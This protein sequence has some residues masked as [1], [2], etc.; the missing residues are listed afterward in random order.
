MKHIDKKTMGELAQTLN[1]EQL[2]LRQELSQIG[3]ENPVT[4]DWYAVPM[5][6]DGD[7]E[8]DYSDQADYVEDFESR[9]A[10]LTEIEKRYKDV[11]DAI[12]KIEAGNYGIC[13]KSGNP[14]EIDRLQANPAARTCKAHMN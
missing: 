13:E 2:S 14:I 11:V 1:S 9:S 5:E 7:A 3:K 12:G 4:G 6:T 8:S 10:R